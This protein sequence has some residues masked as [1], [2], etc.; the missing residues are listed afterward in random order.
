MD[1]DHVVEKLILFV[2]CVHGNNN[3]NLGGGGGGGSLDLLG[4]SLGLF[5]VLA[6]WPAPAWSV[7]LDRGS[8]I[9]DNRRD[10][11]S[12]MLHNTT[13]TLHKQYHITT[14]SQL[15]HKWLFRT[16]RMI[17]TAEVIA[18][19]WQ[20]APAAVTRDLARNLRRHLESS[21]VFH[22]LMRL[23]TA[24]AVFRALKKKNMC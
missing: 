18:L 9:C 24:A 10:L 7:N 23:C 4:K 3:T 20:V 13:Q 11:S 19:A 16:V 14:V 5:G 1:V 22:S 15:N 6:E 12:A 8:K 2:L 21:D 17:Q